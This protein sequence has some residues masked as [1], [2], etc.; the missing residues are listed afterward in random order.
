MNLYTG[1]IVC[2]QCCEDG[3][4]TDYVH[5]NSL[6]QRWYGTYPYN[7]DTLLRKVLHQYFK[8]GIIIED[9]CQVTC[10]CF[11]CIDRLKAGGSVPT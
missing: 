10:V 9:H 8:P 7:F 3:Y 11:D 5:F 6:V 4:Y 1:Q 2:S